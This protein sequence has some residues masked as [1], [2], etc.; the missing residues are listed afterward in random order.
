[1]FLVASDFWRMHLERGQVYVFHLLALSLAAALCLRHDLDSIAGG[2]ALAVLALMR[3]NLL[4]F[5][6]ALL[7]LGR[8]RTGS[9]M[10]ATFGLGVLSTLVFMPS[11]TWSSYFSVGD[12]YYRTIWAPET[13]PD[14]PRPQH[15]GLVEGIDFGHSLTCIESSSLAVLYQTWQER[16]GLP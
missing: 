12:S 16:A 9:V 14:F 5:A 4:I 8:W 2:I 11:G 1:L 15:E 10:L 7:V 3:P 6:P 13:L